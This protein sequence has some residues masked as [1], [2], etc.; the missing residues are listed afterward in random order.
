MSKLK[1][2]KII[3]IEDDVYYSELLSKHI[4][5]HLSNEES[6]LEFN[7]KSYRSA[8]ECLNNLE[9]DTDIV[10]MDYYLENDYGD[11]PFPGLDLL[12]AINAYCFNTRTVVMSAD[13]NKDLPME[14]FR[15]GIYEFIVK[16]KYATDKLSKT[17]RKMIG[18]RILEHYLSSSPENARQNN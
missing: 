15:N 9:K 4:M 6:G 12:Q 11:I 18:D 16:D 13:E 1:K 14:L 2:I 7:I 5:N 17:L 10:I 8:E 3:I